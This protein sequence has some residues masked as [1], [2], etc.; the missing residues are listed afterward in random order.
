MRLTA[1][2]GWC[3]PKRFGFWLVASWLTVLSFRCL[4]AGVDARLTDKSAAY[5]YLGRDYVSMAR[6]FRL[7]GRIW[8]PN[9]PERVSAR[10]LPLYPAFIELGLLSRGEDAVSW[11]KSAQGAL[12]PLC[13]LA[14][15]LTAW[16]ADSLA[17]GLI[18]AALFA[19]SGEISLYSSLVSVEF[20]YMISMI[21]VAAALTR[22]VQVPSAWS[23]RLLGWMLALSLTTRSPLCLFPVVLAIAGLFSPVFRSVRPTIK[24]VL[25][26]AY[27]P[28]IPWT[29]RNAIH[30][31]Q[32][33]PFERH[34]LATNF[35][36][37]SLGLV[38][39]GADAKTRELCDSIRKRQAGDSWQPE[40]IDQAALENIYRAPRRYLLSCVER[41]ARSA[42]AVAPCALLGLAALWVAPL[43]PAPCALGLLIFYFLAIH[44]AFLTESRYLV[45]LLPVMFIWAA[46]G[47]VAVARS[48]GRR[49]KPVGKHPLLDPW[50]PA[51]AWGM[52]F[53]LTLLSGCYAGTAAGLAV[54]TINTE[55]RSKAYLLEDHGG[56]KIA[57]K[58]WS[59]ML[60]R[61]PRDTGLLMERARLRERLEDLPGAAG[62]YQ[63]VLRAF[64]FSPEPSLRLGEIDIHRGMP[65]EAWANYNRAR[66]FAART[67]VPELFLEAEAGLM[68]SVPD[69]CESGALPDPFRR[70]LRDLESLGG[71]PTRTMRGRHFSKNMKP[72][73][74]DLAFARFF[75]CRP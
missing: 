62:D 2:P 5:W 46:C 52:L 54:E 12:A 22:W 45:P 56:E 61:A 29:A 39:D 55:R 35:Y 40:R 58:E 53:P 28:L 50:A 30:F 33:I 16:A 23:A 18:G 37:A 66:A 6:N 59:R 64:P 68:A 67:Q 42:R 8:E 69:A 72:R 14:I 24:T 20:F 47:T 71:P 17:A 25:L 15:F 63:A 48:L 19:L 51:A 4:V 31:R 43:S 13:M 11:V 41:F 36:C 44:A 32:F 75:G 27:L 34:A 9:S 1:L 10:R 70:D 49:W 7:E 60:D 73:R 3:S 38:E 26:A 57:E 74:H 21:G 65:M